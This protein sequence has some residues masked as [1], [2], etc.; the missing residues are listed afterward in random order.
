MRKKQLEN[1]AKQALA[2][3]DPAEAENCRRYSL[4]EKQLRAVRRAGPAPPPSPILIAL[5]LR[6]AARGGERRGA[7]HQVRRVGLMLPHERAEQRAAKLEAAAME[8]EDVLFDD[9]MSLE[10]MFGALKKDD[11]FMSR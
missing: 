1:R 6:R 10:D 7:A 3:V 11:K 2:L 4:S 8:H 5:L 9:G